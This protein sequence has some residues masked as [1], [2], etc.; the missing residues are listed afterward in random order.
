MLER[1]AAGFFA[2]SCTA[3]TVGDERHHR[4]A[5]ARLSENTRVRKARV[6]NLDSLLEC[7]DEEMIFVVLA[8]EPG[9]CE[10]VDVELAV[11]RASTNVWDH[12]LP[13]IYHGDECATVSHPTPA[14]FIAHS[15]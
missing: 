1:D 3:D 12:E 7:A 14:Q 13:G 11:T 2:R 6:I 4:N 5:L 10:A 15:V 9:M 8:H